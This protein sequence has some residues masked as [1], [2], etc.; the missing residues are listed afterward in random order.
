MTGNGCPLCANKYISEHQTKTTQQFILE[1]NI[2]HRGKYSYTKTNYICAKEKVTITCPIHG[3][4]EQTPDIHLRGCGCPKC[5]QSHGEKEVKQYL[6]DNNI[7]F[8]DQYNIIGKERK[9]IIDFY[10]PDYNTF[11]E[12]NGEQHYVP[13]EYF[14]GQIAFEKQQNRDQLLRD[15]CKENNIKLIEISYK[16]N[17]NKVLN[18]IFNLE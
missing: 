6:I 4:F 9:F 15:Y 14:G 2:K 13:K 8:I 1:A 11:I 12:Y 5:N 17:I 18:K 3:D 10:L 16:E 7:K